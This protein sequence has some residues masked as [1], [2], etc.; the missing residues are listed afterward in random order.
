MFFATA[1]V[2]FVNVYWCIVRSESTTKERKQMFVSAT[3]DSEIMPK[4]VKKETFLS[5]MIKLAL[6]EIRHWS[7]PT[8]SAVKRT[9][10]AHNITLRH[11]CSLRRGAFT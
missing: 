11:S 8:L 9:L 10:I 7:F 5:A 1:D 4:V 3:I 6:S 2:S